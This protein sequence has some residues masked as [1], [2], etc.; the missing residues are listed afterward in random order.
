MLSGEGYHPWNC[1]EPS[2]DR[3]VHTASLRFVEAEQN[4]F[5][6]AIVAE[7][8][9]LLR[10]RADYQH[11]LFERRRQPLFDYLGRLGDG[12]SQQTQVRAPAQAGHRLYQRPSRRGHG[13]HAGRR[14]LGDVGAAQVSPQRRFVPAPPGRRHAQR[15]LPAQCVQQLDHLVRIARRVR[16]KDPG[17]IRR[18]SRAHLQHVRGHGDHAGGRQVVQ[19]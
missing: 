18:G 19:P 11:T 1:G 4:R 9:R 6:D 12:G 5:P 8:H 17:Q 2:R 10:S 14:Q 16:R 13:A 15:T 3:Q 7:L